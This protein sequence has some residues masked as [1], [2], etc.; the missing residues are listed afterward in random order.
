MDVTEVSLAVVTDEFIRH[1][2]EAPDLDLDEASGFVVI[3]ATLLDLKAARLL[4]GA[5]V[6]DDQDIA[7]LEARD[8]LFARLLQYRAYRQAADHIE[9]LLAA[10]AGRVPRTPGRDPA[11]TPKLPELV[12]TL[13]ADEFVRLAAEALRPRPPAEVGVGHLHAPVAVAEQRRL[14]LDRLP[15]GVRVPFSRLLTDADDSSTVVARFLALLELYRDGVVTLHQDRPLGDFDV[16]RTA[17]APV[18][19]P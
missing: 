12:W 6:E 4:P 3:A 11:F 15:A 14:L 8:L 7:A 1:L 16:A 18:P 10:N 2:K 19:A 13:T 5:E 9:T 17:P